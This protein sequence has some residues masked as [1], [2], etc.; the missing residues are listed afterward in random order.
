M[1]SANF[2]QSEYSGLDNNT[3]G[4]SEPE[5]ES[6]ELDQVQVQQPSLGGKH[7]SANFDNTTK[8]NQIEDFILNE[9]MDAIQIHKLNSWH[10]I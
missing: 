10:Y 5:D 9:I 7:A 3:P 1:D 6:G 4:D 8:E 2:N